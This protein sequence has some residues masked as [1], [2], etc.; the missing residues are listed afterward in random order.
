MRLKM[1]TTGAI[2]TT[3]G[4]Y[5]CLYTLP[6][7]QAMEVAA[8]HGTSW[9]FWLMDFTSS[10]SIGAITCIIIIVNVI[11]ILSSTDTSID[12]KRNIQEPDKIGVVTKV[13]RLVLTTWSII[14][15]PTCHGRVTVALIRIGRTDTF[16]N[17]K[18]NQVVTTVLNLVFLWKGIMI[19]LFG[20]LLFIIAKLKVFD[21]EF[22]FESNIA[23]KT[24]ATFQ[25]VGLAVSMVDAA[26]M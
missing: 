3:S 25:W 5:L 14:P 4:Q 26:V 22:T 1:I 15:I 20:L 2:T 10:P 7:I 12:T 21:S 6:S 8:T 19:V 11:V 24:L 9:V 17:M 23:S 18:T 13:C 16:A